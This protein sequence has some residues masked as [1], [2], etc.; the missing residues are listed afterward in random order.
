MGGTDWGHAVRKR[1]KY[2]EDQ[3]RN[4]AINPVTM[5]LVRKQI[6]SDIDSLRTAAGLHAY[7]GEDAATV[8]NLLGRV[9]Y[10]VCY[11]AGIHQL[12]ETPEARILAGTANALGDLADSSTSLEAQRD[13][14]TAGLAAVDRL[15]PRL[16]VAALA[17]GALQLD[18]LLTQGHVGTGDVNRALARQ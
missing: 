10:I 12:G 13:T 7:I 9:V 16:S 8:T 11:A 17:A 2:R 5:A 15:M 14:L 6:A 18:H 1:S 4:L 3:A